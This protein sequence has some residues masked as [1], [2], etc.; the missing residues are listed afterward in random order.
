M[1][2]IEKM[3]PKSQAS[4]SSGHNCGYIGPKPSTPGQPAQPK[5]PKRVRPRSQPAQ[6]RPTDP[7][8]EYPKGIG[9][10]SQSA[11]ERSAN[12]PPRRPGISYLGRLFNSS[13][14]FPNRQ[15]YQTKLPT[16][17]PHYKCEFTRELTPSPLTE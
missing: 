11:H 3:T 12:P 16:D 4:G 13:V 10:R 9:P 7:P 5:S 17:F 15:L 1:E 14:H 6:K 8:P 2:I